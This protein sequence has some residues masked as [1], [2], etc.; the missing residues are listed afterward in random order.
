[1]RLACFNGTSIAITHLMPDP[2]RENPYEQRRELFRYGIEII[3]R[4][5]VK[6]QTSACT[7]VL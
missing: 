1:M 2:E 3:E 7:D 4:L 6:L 5:Q